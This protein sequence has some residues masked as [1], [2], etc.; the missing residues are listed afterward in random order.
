MKEGIINALVKS[1]EGTNIE[2]I[3]NNAHGM[4]FSAN[5]LKMFTTGAAEQTVIQFSLSKPFDLRD[6]V[7]LDGEL[8]LTDP[9]NL[10]GINFSN[11][12]LK[13]FVTDYSDRGILEYNLSCSFGVVKCHDPSTDADD[14]ATTQSQTEI[15]GPWF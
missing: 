1:Y 2:A 6:K 5:G 3:E 14:T 7:T 8:I 4:I 10:G 11:D 9:G 13:M 12:G 15:P